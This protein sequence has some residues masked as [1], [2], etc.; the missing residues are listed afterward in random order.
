[1]ISSDPLPAR[2]VTCR[3]ALQPRYNS[4]RPPVVRPPRTSRVWVVLVSLK[5]YQ[6]MSFAVPKVPDWAAPVGADAVP[7]AAHVPGRSTDEVR[8]YVAVSGGSPPT[9]GIVW[10]RSPPSDQ[11]ANVH[12]P[13]PT[14][15]VRGAVT[16]TV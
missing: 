12:S 8:A 5:R 14:F 16:C 11:F 4:I 10:V 3:S 2:S 13:S 15:A 9:T 1:M 7:A 6:S